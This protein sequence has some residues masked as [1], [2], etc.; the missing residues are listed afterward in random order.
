MGIIKNT[1]YT[2]SNPKFINYFKSQP[3]FPY[4]HV[5]DDKEIFHI[6]HLYKFKNRQQF[7]EDLNF[8]LENYHQLDPKDIIRKKIPPNSFLLSFDDGLSQVYTDVYPILKER[9]IKAV[10]FINPDYIDNKTIMYKHGLSLLLE[11]LK[12]LKA[13]DNFIIQARDKI[14]LD[15]NSKED[16]IDKIK[17]ISYTERD[18]INELLS[19]FKIDIDAYLENVKPYLTKN[20]IKTMVADGFY[21]G[22]HTMSHPPLTALSEFEQKKEII[23]SI[24]WLKS[25]FDIKY[26]FFA[27][28]FSDKKISKKVINDLFKYDKDLL[29][30]GNSGLKKDISD[31]II[32]RFSLEKPNKLGSRQIITE[33]LYKQYNRFI[34]KY[35][36]K[37]K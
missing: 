5:V 33:N 36:I 7:I 2:F 1:L 19:V 10:F 8:L 28:P 24:E 17:K 18:K 22:G 20:Q 34:G 15:F 21:F 12:T 37:R 9:K 16:L 4:Y 6:K 14:Y 31:R 3:I 23:N 30:F 29:L 27:F 32:Q 26:S 35:V 25:N 13:D 11:K